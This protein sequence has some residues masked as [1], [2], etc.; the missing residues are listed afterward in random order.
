MH[1]HMR[2]WATTQRRGPPT[3]CTGHAA[4]LTCSL[5]R[6]CCMASSSSVSAR[7]GGGGA[8]VLGPL[9]APPSTAPPPPA[10]ECPLG[11]RGGRI[12]LVCLAWAE[13]WG[14]SG[15]GPPAAECAARGGPAPAAEP[16]AAEAGRWRCWRAALLSPRPGLL[17]ALAELVLLLPWPEAGF[18]PPA[19]LRAARASEDATSASADAR[20]A[21]PG[22]RGALCMWLSCCC[23]C[24]GGRGQVEGC[25]PRSRGWWVGTAQ[26]VGG[27]AGCHASRSSNWGL[28]PPA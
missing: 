12:W 10:A 7:L 19:A 28:A 3:A 15:A 25:V 23:C 2:S 27:R 22:G 18:A 20:L 5:R 4:S 8:V 11:C 17:P 24:C 16:S 21:E 14:W 13:L 1:L 6:S 26:S 9:P